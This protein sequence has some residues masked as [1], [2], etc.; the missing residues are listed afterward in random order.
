MTSPWIRSVRLVGS[1]LIA[2]AGAIHLWL[3]FDYFRTVHVIGVLFLVNTGVAAAVAAVIAL[4][5]ALWATFAGV[6]YAAG[7]LGAF[8]LSVYHGLFGYMESLNGSWQLAAAGVEG[9][10]I[11]ALVAVAASQRPQS[12]IRDAAYRGQR[13]AYLRRQR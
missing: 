5:Q 12:A 2:A 8:F 9:G 4:S 6:A 11:V 10:A 7:T 13:Q 1:L 3:Y